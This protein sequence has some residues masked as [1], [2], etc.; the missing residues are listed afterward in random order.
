MLKKRQK[1]ATCSRQGQLDRKG[2][3]NLDYELKLCPPPP[4]RF[5]PQLSSSI[6]SRHKFIQYRHPRGYLCLESFH[7]RGHFIHVNKKG[8]VTLRKATLQV[9]L[10]QAQP[11]SIDQHA[12]PID[13]RFLPD[14]KGYFFVSKRME[15]PCQ[16]DQQLRR[17]ATTAPPRT[18]DDALARA[19]ALARKMIRQRAKVN[20]E[21]VSTSPPEG[22][23][24]A[25]LGNNQPQW[26]SSTTAAPTAI[27]PS[28]P[29]EEQS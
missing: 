15:E 18:T 23:E 12:D 11:E 19:F 16:Q 21:I 4:L 8:I 20:I 5:C 6:T 2:D 1:K 29:G 10:G 25:W 27:E 28:V 24:Q 7:K 26:H 17:E 9:G 13:R 3:K 14:I 22:H